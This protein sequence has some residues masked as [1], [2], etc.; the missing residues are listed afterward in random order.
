MKRVIACAAIMA[1][2]WTVPAAAADKLIISS[3][4]GSWKDLI[5][6]TVAKKFTADTGVR[7]RLD[8]AEVGPLPSDVESELFRIAGEAL[9]NIRKHAQA[10]DASVGLAAVRGRLRLVV[11]DNGRGFNLRRSRSAGFGLSGIEDRARAIGGRAAIRSTPGRGTTITV[12]VPI[13][14][15]RP[16]EDGHLAR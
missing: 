8:I 9:T 4:G 5:T 12:T 3:W 10:R 11:G 14:P 13:D 6:E 1:A 16:P 7:V 2:I 15:D